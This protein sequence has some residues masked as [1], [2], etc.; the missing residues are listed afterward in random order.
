[1][2]EK[3]KL[4]V[5][6]QSG[7]NLNG[8]LTSQN[9]PNIHTS[10]P[11]ETKGKRKKYL[12][13][14]LILFL[15]VVAIVAVVVYS[16]RSD[17]LQP[18]TSTEA[19]NAARPQYP[20]GDYVAGY[21]EYNSDAFEEII[22]KLKIQDT[23][24]QEFDEQ[25]R[26]KVVVFPGNILGFKESGLYLYDLSDNKVLKLT[27]G[28]GSPRIM[29]DHFIVYGSAQQ[30]ENSTLIGF[31]LLNLK[32]GQNTTIVNGDMFEFADSACCGVSPNGFKLAIPREDK[33]D[34]WDIRDNSTE[35]FSVR[36]S[37]LSEN[38]PTGE[39]FY[40]DTPY[41]TEIGYPTPTW[42]DNETL[43]FAD[44]TPTSVRIDE[45]GAINHD[46]VNNTIYKLSVEDGV[47]A[48]LDGSE[49][50]NYDIYARN[51]GKTVFLVQSDSIIEINLSENITSDITP[52]TSDIVWN[53]FNLAG[54]RLYTFPVLH[55]PDA[56]LSYNL[57]PGIFEP[58]HFNPLP[59]ELKEIDVTQILPETW[60]D[61]NLMLIKITATNSAINKEY[62]AIYDTATDRVLQY[63]EI[64]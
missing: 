27:S 10:A 32:T 24:K 25:D 11:A 15:V 14:F 4:K 48:K 13:I 17:N 41:Y 9:S 54:N 40:K 44:G 1:M 36:L 51:D 64:E 58:E 46:P 47:A 59:E 29:S 16:R 35:T 52:E 61:D 39:E 2:D 21:L 8:N 56:Y 63:I 22:P 50:K 23:I 26:N 12:I 19:L 5:Q 49:G 37:P 42:L 53:M 43:L 45:D 34:I 7:T 60:L 20:S 57:N 3:E 31:E 28:G 62:E 6:S 55:E 18:T 38:F 33:I 30:Q